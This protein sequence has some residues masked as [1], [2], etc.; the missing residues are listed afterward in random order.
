VNFEVA[1][2]FATPPAVA[3]PQ[4]DPLAER[5]RRPILR[6]SRRS[7]S[8]GGSPLVGGLP[9]TGRFFCEYN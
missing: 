1:D 6:R 3:H 8:E 9:Y 5:P 2:L 4:Q 7:S